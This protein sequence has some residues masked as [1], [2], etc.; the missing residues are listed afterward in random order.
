MSEHKSCVTRKLTPAGEWARYYI[1]H[2]DELPKNAPDPQEDPGGFAAWASR[3]LPRKISLIQ[4]QDDE[5]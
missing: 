5:R 2:P 4:A 3:N 1:D